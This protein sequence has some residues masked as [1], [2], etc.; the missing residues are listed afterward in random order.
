MQKHSPFLSTVNAVVLIHQSL[1]LVGN[2][3]D[4]ERGRQVSHQGEWTS[5]HDYLNQGQILIA[6][7]SGL[8]DKEGVLPR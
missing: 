6:S 1:I 3:V 4:M 7:F 8:L 5:L 2:K